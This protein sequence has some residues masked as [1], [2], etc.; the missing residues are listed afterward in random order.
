VWWFNKASNS[1]CWCNNFGATINNPF[2]NEVQSVPA[3]IET[4]RWIKT[5]SRGCN[6]CLAA[7]PTRLRLWLDLRSSRNYQLEPPPMW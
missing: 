7:T 1:I 2:S 3:Q 5:G 6:H 4:S